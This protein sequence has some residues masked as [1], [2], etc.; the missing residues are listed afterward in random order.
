MSNDKNDLTD[1]IALMCVMFIAMIWLM[2]LYKFEWFVAVWYVFKAPFYNLISFVPKEYFDYIFN[3]EYLSKIGISFPNFGESLYNVAQLFKNTTF[4]KIYDIQ[5]YESLL[6]ENYNFT[7]KQYIGFVNSLTIKAMFPFTAFYIYYITK[8][9]IKKERFKKHYNVQTLGIQESKIWPQIRPIIYETES[10]INCKSLDSGWFAMAAKP[11]EYMIK[12]DILEEFKYDDPDNYELFGKTYFKLNTDKAYNVLSSEL[13]EKWNGVDNLLFEE[14]AFLSIVIPKIMRDKNL[15]VKMNANLCIMHSSYPDKVN[16]NP[17]KI[18]SYLFTN[19]IKLFKYI[20]NIKQLNSTRKRIFKEIK[21]TKKIVLKDID[22]ILDKYLREERVVTK[23]FFFKKTV[24]NDIHPEI[25]RVFDSH[26]YKKT[27]FISILLLAR[28]SGVLAS[29]DLIWVK[30][31][32]R[33]LWYCISQVG[34]TASFVE[35]AGT[36]SHYL[37]ELK[38]EKKLSTPMVTNA[39]KA[40]DKYMINTHDN[41]KKIEDDY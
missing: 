32:N 16:Y 39:I 11:K 21:S 6:N 31:I 27:V 14:K 10:F 30:K 7:L 29:C 4:E 13:G 33:D 3:N 1:G 40:M 19:P 41:Y 34:R 20:K 26:F 35:C 9:I 37:T 18:M 23:Y 28:E 12:K 17:I 38:V 22:Y 25:K 36:W 24:K 5:K 2:W 15:S 8:K